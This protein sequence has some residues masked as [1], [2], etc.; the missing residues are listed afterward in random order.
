MEI[1]Y[2]RVAGIDVGKKEIAVTVRVPGEGPGAGRV[3]VTRKFTTFYPV[4]A[5][6]AAWLVEQGV[7]HVVMEST[8]Y[9]RPVFHAVCEADA[10]LE[11]LLVN[12]GH[13]KNVPGRKTDVKDS[14]WLAQLL[15]VGLLRG[16]FIPP[17]EIAAIREVTRYRKKLI[18]SHTSEL[19]RLGKVCEDVGIKIDSVASSLTTKS[20]RD[21]LEALIAGERDPRVLA[22]L[23][24][25]VMRKKIPDLSMALAGRFAAHHAVLAR[26]HLD[27]LDHL[28]VMIARLDTQIEEMTAPFG[29]Q[30]AALC[31]IPGIGDRLAQVII[32]E[33]G[34]DMGRFPTAD[35]LASWAG[36]CPG[37]NESAGKHGNTRTR[38]GNREIRTALV[39]AAWA[40]ARTNTYLGARFRRLH[41]RFGKKNGGKA[42]VAI[43]HN[44]LVIIW[45]VL[46]DGVEFYD[47]GPDYF[48]RPGTSATT[49]LKD[50]LIQELRALGYTVTLQPT[51]A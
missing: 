39:E 43:A 28:E 30:V 42:A 12:A 4:L 19:Q 10:D 13:V 15:E 16:S 1:M 9:W 47:L 24:R 3:E 11:I 18:Q 22:D 2:E 6:M 32:S 26:L 20:A 31:T 46:R 23:A 8:V 45:Y 35:H 37:N 36:L 34:V 40:T 27:H 51:A 49:R 14:Q 25:G 33:I 21:M 50:H 17:A 44:L 38:K 5:V 41:R 48:T 29:A 7:T